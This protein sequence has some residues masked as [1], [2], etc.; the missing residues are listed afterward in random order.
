MKILYESIVSIPSEI[1]VSQSIR[2]LTEP[3][4]LIGNQRLSRVYMVVVTDPVLIVQLGSDYIKLLGTVYTGDP[5]AQIIE[6]TIP[7]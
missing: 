1:G 3:L 7:E 6:A 2:V 5:G 4:T